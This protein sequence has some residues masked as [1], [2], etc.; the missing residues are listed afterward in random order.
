[1]GSQKIAKFHKSA[2][3]PSN[4]N[5][6]RILREAGRP[7]ASSA[8]EEPS[9]PCG[10]SLKPGGTSSGQVPPVTTSELYQ[11][12]QAVGV[13]T[14]EWVVPGRKTK[15]KFFLFADMATKL[16]VIVPLKTYEVMEMQAET[17]DD[18][19]RAFS[20][21][22]LGQY[23]KPE[24]LILDAAKTFTSEKFHEFASQP[25]SNYMWWRRRQLGQTE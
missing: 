7:E 13:D 18:V 10:L 14:S 12:W 3:H 16:R 22:W 21:K 24:I 9:V 5:L 1:M 6:A 19:I 4:S 8:C 20:E 25:T 15:V 17:T 2:G 11:A 23:P